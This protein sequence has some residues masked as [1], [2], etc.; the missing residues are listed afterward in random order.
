MKGTANP[1]EEMYFKNSWGLEG[2]ALIT[3]VMT[4]RKVSL[5]L[6][7]GG[8]ANI[9]N[10]YI[11]CGQLTGRVH[12]HNLVETCSEGNSDMCVNISA[13]QNTRIYCCWPA[14]HTHKHTH[15]HTHT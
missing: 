15:T 5:C 11:V 8:G 6:H 12:N 4:D 2:D 14:T 9:I 10:D 3:S 7:K 1:E 13:T